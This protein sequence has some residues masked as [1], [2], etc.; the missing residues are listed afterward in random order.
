M[1][2]K[3]YWANLLLIVE[4]LF[5]DNGPEVVFVELSIYLIKH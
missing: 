3:S 1:N 5:L 4:I 2:K